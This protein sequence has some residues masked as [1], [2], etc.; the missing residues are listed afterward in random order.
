M[1]QCLWKP[2]INSVKYLDSFDEAILKIENAHNLYFYVSM[3]ANDVLEAIEEEKEVAESLNLY[4][5]FV[6]DIGLYIALYE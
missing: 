2:L 4:L 3:D 6:Y 1:V 5:I